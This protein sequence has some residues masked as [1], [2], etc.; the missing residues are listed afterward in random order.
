[1]NNIKYYKTIS[2]QDVDLKSNFLVLIDDFFRNN[3]TISAAFHQSVE[4]CH[5]ELITIAIL[6][7]SIERFPHSDISDILYH[8]C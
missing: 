8:I 4:D 1:M 7:H 6:D 2:F 5:T 3:L